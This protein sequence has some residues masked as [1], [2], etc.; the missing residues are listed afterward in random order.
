[1]KHVLCNTLLLTL[2]IGFGW[3]VT[4]AWADDPIN[5]SA[6][7]VWIGEQDKT[8]SV[9]WG[10]MDGDGYL[11]LAVGN[12]GSDNRGGPNRVYRNTNGLLETTPVWTSTSEY[13]TYSVV[14]GDVDQ[15]GDLDLAVG[16]NNIGGAPNELYL[17]DNGL[18]QSTAVWTTENDSTFSV[19]WGDMN[20]DGYLDLA[21]GNYFE[22]NK[23]Y[24]NN[25]NGGLSSTPVWTSL[26]DDGTRSVAWGDVDGDGDLDLAVGNDGPENVDKIYLNENGILQTD[27]DNPWTSEDTDG[28]YSVAWGDVDGDGRLELATGNSLLSAAGQVNRVY[29][30]NTET[31]LQ[32]EDVWQSVD[33]KITY[34]LAWGDADGDGDL[35]LAA[36]NGNVVESGEQNAIYLNDAGTLQPSPTFFSD[37]TDSTFSV[38]WGDMDADGDLDLAAGNN[39]F[40]GSKI[41]ANHEPLLQTTAAQSLNTKNARSMVW[42][43]MD[44][45]GELDLAVGNIGGGFGTQDQ[46]YLNQ[47]GFLNLEWVSD[48]KDITSSMAWGDVDGDGDLDLAVGKGY[49]G[50]FPD[51]ANKVYRNNDG[52]LDI[53]PMWR[54]GDSDGIDSNT[55]SLAWGDMDGDGDL[56]L[57][58]GNNEAANKVYLNDGETLKENA[59]W[60]S[61]DEDIT[62]SVAW[63]DVDNDGDLDLAV[64]NGSVSFRPG[65]EYGAFNR[66]YINEGGMLEQTTASWVSDEHDMT[67][68]VAWGDMNGDGYLDLAVGNLENPNRVYLN[69]QGQLETTASWIS[70]DTDFSQSVAWGDVDGDGDLDLAVGNND[71]P[72]KIHLNQNGVLQTNAVWKAAVT[73]STD[74]VA[75]GD[76]DHDGDLD[77]AVGNQQGDS[78]I[79]LNPRRTPVSGFDNPAHLTLDR[80]GLTDDAAFFST[81]HIIKSADIPIAYTLFDQEDDPVLKIFPEY[82]LNS[83]GEWFPASPGAGGDGVTNLAASAWPTGTTH[84]FMWD[85]ASDVIKN[86]NVVFRIRAQSS[87]NH[88]PILW[89]ALASQSFSFRVESAPWFVKVVDEAGQAV[90]DAHVYQAGQLLTDSNNG[91]TDP[92]GLLRL[93]NPVAGQSLVALAPVREQ[94]TIREIHENWAYRVYLTNMNLDPDG[95]PQPEFIGEPGQQLLTV[96]TKDPLVLF[97]LVVSIEWDADETY[98]ETIKSA[99]QRASGYLYDVTDG[100]MAFGQVTI[101]DKAEHWADADYQISTK[102]TVRPYA[103]WGGITSDDT[104]H[105]IRVGRF[106]DGGSGNAGSWDEPDGYRTLIHEFGHYALNLYDE[107]KYLEFEDGR[108]KEE[109]GAAC[110]SDIIRTNTTDAT[111][112]SIMF[113]QYNASELADVSRWNEDCQLTEQARHTGGQADWQTVVEY[114]PEL[115]RPDERGGKMAGPERFPSE[116]LPFPEVFDLT[117]NNSQGL[118]REL[119]V[120]EPG[121]SDEPVHNALVALYTTPQSYTIAIDQGLT[122]EAGKITVYGAADGDGIRVATFDGAMAGALTVDARTSYTLRLSSLEITSLAARAANEVPYLSMTPQSDGT[123]LYLE[124]AGLNQASLPLNASVVPAKGGGPPQSTVLA[125]SSAEDAYVGT[126]SLEGVGLGTGRAQVTGNGLTQGGLTTDYNLQYVEVLTDSTLYSEDG[127]FALELAPHS[128][129]DDADQYATVLPTGYVP[130]PLPAGKAVIGSAYEVRLSGAVNVFEKEGEVRLH[131]HPEVMGEFEDIA[132]YIWD[133]VQEQWQLLGGEVNEVDNAWSVVVERPGIYALMGVG[134]GQALGAGEVYLPLIIK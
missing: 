17:N 91:V 38:A 93:N 65:D 10:D 20:G 55:Y 46:V 40:S 29:F 103:F 56:D 129:P 27:A 90:A 105:A 108:F 13:L 62:Y 122:D 80:P 54:E 45:D 83:G 49:L 18:L 118:A 109:K 58:V 12:A 70:T 81:P 25:Q 84:T 39:L 6:E 14:W 117:T 41:Y 73:D 1:M 92:A 57:A 77:L 78:E 79:Y 110:T 101:Y 71:D 60:I 35:D 126:T 42:G 69:N 102:N 99:F 120:L 95:L 24:L 5:L 16:N 68:S 43:D 89:S 34:S 86:D 133:P 23:V 98:V 111:N 8:Y 131:Y 31:G 113:W 67:Y 9:A 132:I 37:D 48:E 76:V 51:A 82:S 125:Y 123:S 33:K 127:N 64:G 96:R 26:D 52:Q 36:G 106:W 115:S 32:T 7:A 87:H 63:G 15:D 19:A 85:A 22:E 2:L 72:N 107:Y 116:L 11:D 124:V 134:S 66:L 119:T 74:T 100:Q 47:Q 75:W 94:S 130:G 21:V 53:T 50:I 112:A 88:G 59:D 128:L 44:R 61:Y 97:N 30:F 4:P 121:F 104:A 3:C 114:Y 28:T